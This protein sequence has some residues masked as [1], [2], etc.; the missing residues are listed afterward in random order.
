[1]NQEIKLRYIEFL[2]KD[3]IQY[4]LLLLAMSSPYVDNRNPKFEGF[5]NKYKIISDY[6]PRRP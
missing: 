1:M 6:C 5:W 3:M 2:S 4:L